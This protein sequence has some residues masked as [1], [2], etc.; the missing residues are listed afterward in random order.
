MSS[1][2]DIYFSTFSEIIRLTNCR[3]PHFAKK[4]GV[5]MPW[6]VDFDRTDAQN[7]SLNVINQELYD[8][9]E[10]Y[11]NKSDAFAACSS[12]SDC[13][14]VFDENC[15]GIG[16]FVIGFRA[17]KTFE[18]SKSGNGKEFNHD[19]N[20]DCLFEKGCTFSFVDMMQIV[21]HTINI[22]SLHA[23]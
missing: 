22:F 2:V 12:N 8:Q 5:Q 20:D 10:K 15:D 9:Y 4:L 14:W 11:D 13:P 23:N 1:T 18:C 21:Y 3:A 6:N 17:K 19:C 7:A 16:P